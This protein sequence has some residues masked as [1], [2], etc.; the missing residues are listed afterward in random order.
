MW[1]GRNGLYLPVN[2]SMSLKLVSNSWLNKVLYHAQNKECMKN[3]CYYYVQLFTT[4]PSHQNI[5]LSL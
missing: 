3:V 5:L 1:G 4:H 2:A